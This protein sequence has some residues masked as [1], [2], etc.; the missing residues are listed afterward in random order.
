VHLAPTDEQQAIA[1]TARAFLERSM[2]FTPADVVGGALAACPDEVWSQCADLG[3]FGLSVPENVGGVGYG[4]VERMFLFVELGR[5][6]APG[7]FL[8]TVT[9]AEVAAGTDL[10]AALVAGGHRVA[11]G[12]AEGDGATVTDADGTDLVLVVGPDRCSLHE[13][14]PGAVDLEASVDSLTTIGRASVLGPALVTGDPHD[15]TYGRAL[16]RN[17]A[18]AVGLARRALADSVAHVSDRQQFGRPIGSFQAVRHRCSDM[19]VRAE[20]AEAQ[21]WF[22]AASADA[23]APDTTYQALA[24][25]VVAG[26]AAIGNAADNI[27]NH[28]AI[29]FTAEHTAHLLATR[30]RV[31]ETRL[32][33]E[34]GRLDLLAAADRPRQ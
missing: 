33:G 22:S 30:A 34:R 2:A 6:I 26:P 17:A 1:D 31:L 29:G 5:H 20:A 12:Q 4:L 32:G 8:A 15:R 14:D 27:Q 10:G 18:L 25:M 28:G 23:G 21:L 13:L 24:A 19:A 3:W 11:L 9:A 7:P 16:V